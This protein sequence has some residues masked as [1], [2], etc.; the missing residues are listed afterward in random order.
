MPNVTAPLPSCPAG[1]A[2]PRLAGIQ[3]ACLVEHEQQPPSPLEQAAQLRGAIL[4]RLPLTTFATGNAI[5]HPAAAHL[6]GRLYRGVLCPGASPPLRE[7]L[8]ELAQVPVLIDADVERV[9]SIAA[10][11]RA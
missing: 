2:P 10:S 8:A 4:T 1:R 3:L 11:V 5:H 9:D 6:L 7:A